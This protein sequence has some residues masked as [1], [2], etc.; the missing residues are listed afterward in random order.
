M[1]ERILTDEKKEELRIH[2]ERND[3][4]VVDPDFKELEDYLEKNPSETTVYL[5]N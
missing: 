1:V 2:I 3:G 4:R 5:D